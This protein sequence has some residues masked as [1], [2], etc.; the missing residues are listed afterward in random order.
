MKKSILLIV[1]SG[2][3]PSIA[4]VEEMCAEKFDPN[5]NATLYTNCVDV[6]VGD[7]QMRRQGMAN[8]FQHMGD[9]FKRNTTNCETTCNFGT[10]YTSCR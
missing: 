3:F 10:C 9:G 7:I 1:L 2:C 5:T 4:Q 6:R 8:A